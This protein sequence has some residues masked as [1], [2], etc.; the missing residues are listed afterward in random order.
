MSAPVALGLAVLLLLL[1]VRGP[2]A[3]TQVNAESENDGV[4]VAD[5]T[6]A[7]RVR[8]ENAFPGLTFPWMVHITHAGDGSDRLWVVLKHGRIVVFS[9][10]WNVK[11]YTDFLDIGD[12]V[13][14]VAVEEG[15][16]GLAFD[17]GY[18]TNGYFYITYSANDPK[19]LVVS[20]FSVLPTDPDRADPASE[21]VI[22]EVDQ[23]SKHHQGGT[24]VF[25]EDG[26]LYIGLG[27]GGPLGDPDKQGQNTS[28]LLAT[29]IRID[30][31][32]A[33]VA[34]PYRIP[35]DNPFAG[36]AAPVRGEI[37]AYGLRNPWNFSFDQL[38]GDLWVGDVG[39]HN[40]EEINVVK[41][42]RNY[43]WSV[44]EGFHCFPATQTVCDQ[45]GKDLPL[46]E[47]AHGP[48]C[49]IVGGHV[50]RGH[51]VPDLVGRYIYGDFCTGRVWG[52]SYDGQSVTDN[53]L[54]G[55]LDALIMGIGVDEQ[56]EPYILSFDGNIYRLVV[57][58]AVPV[59]SVSWW[60]LFG[61]ALGLV[62]ASWWRL[63]SV[64]HSAA[65]L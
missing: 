31:A 16:L 56:L 10:R 48:E 52:L 34:E 20:R 4:P 1:L 37:W 5:A 19:R 13:H 65:R 7:G 53:V 38:T 47:Y 40:W 18:A 21:L 26:F 24:L 22:L 8:L 9:N 14:S 42:G 12:K 33:S 58:S 45:S 25:G 55:D 60:G 64:R 43:G 61:L 50:Y 27:D 6:L 57:S 17:P 41:R 49:A 2:F 44:M 3:P 62:A 11:T 51:L 15:L 35:A 30:V 63:V 39:S 32:N 36:L 23:P 54:L 28:T 46:F 59:P 29:I